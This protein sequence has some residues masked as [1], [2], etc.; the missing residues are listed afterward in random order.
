VLETFPLV[1]RGSRDAAFA[2][3]RHGAL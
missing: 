2:A 3:F 1:D